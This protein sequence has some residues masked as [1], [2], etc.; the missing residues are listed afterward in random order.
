[1]FNFSA[2]RNWIIAGDCP[3]IEKSG[4]Y[5]IEAKDGNKTP[6]IFPSISFER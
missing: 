1:M 4:W 5:L 6:K 2:L 3:I